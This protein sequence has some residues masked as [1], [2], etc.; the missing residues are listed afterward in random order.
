MR[1]WHVA[2]GAV[3][4]RRAPP[5]LRAPL[6]IV[7]AA[8]LGD[9]DE[10][11]AS[12]LWPPVNA[13]APFEEYARDEMGGGDEVDEAAVSALIL[14]RAELRQQRSYE[15]ADAILERLRD[16]YGVSVNDYKRTWR[17]ERG[18][19]HA[20]EYGGGGGLR[21]YA[22]D[23]RDRD[24]EVDEG[25]VL[26]LLSERS[27]LR[28]ERDYAGADAI[29]EELRSMGVE[30]YDREMMWR[31]ERPER[32]RRRSVSRV[33][34]DD[35]G[36]FVRDPDDDAEVNAEL[37]QSLIAERA[38]L[39]AAREYQEADKIR[40][41]LRELNVYVSDR[42]RWWRVD[43]AALTRR[44]RQR[45]D[46]LPNGHD[47]ERVDG[48]EAELSE[49][50]LQEIHAILSE[51]LTA[52][53]ERNFERADE[54]LEKLGAIGVQ[55]NDGRKA[56]RADGGGFEARPYVRAGGGGE[57]DAEFVA[58]AL[59]ERAAARKVRDYARADALALQ[60][61]QRGIHIDDVHRTWE[62]MGAG[63]DTIHYGIFRTPTTGLA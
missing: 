7:C 6:Q 48:D 9:L 43:A 4:A 31:V 25:R 8:P 59:A 34:W 33:G 39:R 3:L 38:E 28:R 11:S 10:D 57:V 16:E 50:Q 1:E 22:R 49:E 41:R 2:S 24:A 18:A 62:V 35:D 14:H 21:E 47:Y 19:A 20:D 32:R 58:A 27:E 29:R 5:C 40:E 15:A 52:K 60:L 45:P 17:S 44:S 36:R 42:E 55:V 53:L 63:S 61:A 54:L 46:E 30:V 12:R 56:W 51:R 13:G 26:A 23:Y 37:V